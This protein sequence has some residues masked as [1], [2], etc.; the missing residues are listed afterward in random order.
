[1]NPEPNPI[2]TVLYTPDGQPVYATVTP[3]LAAPLAVI[4]AHTVPQPTVIPG[5]A[6]LPYYQ[7]TPLPP[8]AVQAPT[9]YSPARDPW[10]IRLLAGG[11]GLGAAGVGLSFLFAA[12]A[13]ATTAIGLLL[14]VV[15]VVWLLAHSGGSGRGGAVNV[16]VHNR[17]N[18]RNR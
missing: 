3:G 17:M 1:V 15:A 11:I 4:P 5:A 9:G 6:P 8:T 10:V 12:L 13:A 14:G 18:N 2:P 7:P 16:T